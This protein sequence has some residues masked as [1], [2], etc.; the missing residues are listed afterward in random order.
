MDKEIKHSLLKL[1]DHLKVVEQALTELA[2]EAIQTDAR[3][4]RLEVEHHI[5]AEPLDMA[6]G[7]DYPPL[8][9]VND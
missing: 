7:N 4:K 8:I 6:D 5:I 3:L 1:I 9:K 2:L